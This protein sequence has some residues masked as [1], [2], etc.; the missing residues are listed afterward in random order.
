MKSF[1]IKFIALLVSIIS[2]S[3]CSQNTGTKSESNDQT[4]SENPTEWTE[5]L[6]KYEALVDKNNSLQSRIKSG[7]MNAVQEVSEIS[8]EMIELSEKLQ[9]GKG[10]MN[11]SESKRMIDIMSKIK[12]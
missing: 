8:K 2:I 6:D 7:D 1:K 9:Q 3:A 10:S 5:W 4:A 11:A 12:Y